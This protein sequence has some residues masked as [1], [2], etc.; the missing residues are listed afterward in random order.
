MDA[1][2]ED[3]RANRAI[4]VGFTKPR[5]Q[6]ACNIDALLDCTLDCLRTEFDIHHALVL[7]LDAANARLYTVA[8]MGYEDSGVGSRSSPPQVGRARRTRAGSACQGGPP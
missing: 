5:S 4:A 2:L 3:V 8:S 6:H 7:M 1:V